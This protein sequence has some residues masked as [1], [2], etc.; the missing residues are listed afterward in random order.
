M[1]T[2]LSV[3]KR[4]KSSKIEHYFLVFSFLMRVDNNSWFNERLDVFGAVSNRPTVLYRQIQRW[5]INFLT[6]SQTKLI[7]IKRTS[8]AFK[9]I[10]NEL[11]GND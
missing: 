10:L 2:V 7:K 9:S 8:P 3:D 1:S 4:R 6:N 5:N 11:N